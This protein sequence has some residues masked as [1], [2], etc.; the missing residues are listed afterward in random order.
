[1]YRFRD[2]DIDITTAY[3]REKL[4]LGEIEK[5]RDW[6]TEHERG[7]DELCNTQWWL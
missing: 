6:E 3:T 5:G 7:K 2:I 1:M 4:E